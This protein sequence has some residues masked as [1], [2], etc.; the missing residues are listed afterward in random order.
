MSRELRPFVVFG[1]A[2]THDAL[3]AEARLGE[4]GVDCVPIPTPKAVRAGCGIAL[5]LLPHDESRAA[6]A[7]EEAGI[8]VTIRADIEDV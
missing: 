2:S 8:K 4:T 7:L 3:E 1:F 6:E 5:R